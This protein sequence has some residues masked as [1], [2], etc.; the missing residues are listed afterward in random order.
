[1]EALVSA[2][3]YPESAG[4]IDPRRGEE[5]QVVSQFRC[6]D[7]G[8]AGMSRDK[9]RHGEA[10]APA[11]SGPA[12]EADCGHIYRTSSGIKPRHWKRSCGHRQRQTRRSKR[13]SSS[14]QEAFPEQE[15][16]DRPEGASARW[17]RK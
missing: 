2:Q 15:K 12:S 5:S 13:R 16:T 11:G 4:N 6:N 10:L 9:M 14:I 8:L 7:A 1:M 17:K 3:C